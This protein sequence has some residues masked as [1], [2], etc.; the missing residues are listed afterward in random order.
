MGM[1]CQEAALATHTYRK[2][3]SPLTV[4][5]VRRGGAQGWHKVLFDDG[6]IVEYSLPNETWRVAT[7]E[8]EAEAARH[9]CVAFPPAHGPPL[10]TPGG[11]PPPRKRSIH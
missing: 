8:D 10:H 4:H 5:A 3:I 9:G 2:Q 11:G 1:P 7:L 6:D